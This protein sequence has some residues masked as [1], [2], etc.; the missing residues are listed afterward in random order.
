MKQ[1]GRS[2]AEEHGEA[3]GIWLDTSALKN[4]KM[5]TL[6]AKPTLSMQ[7]RPLLYPVPE[8]GPLPFTKQT[9]IS[10]FFRSQPV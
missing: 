10:A 6:I 2:P 9:T 4:R 3:C 8:K 7:N 5:Q 1:K